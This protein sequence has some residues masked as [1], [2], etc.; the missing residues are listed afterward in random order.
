MGGIFGGSKPKPPPKPIPPKVIPQ[1]DEA[2]AKKAKKKDISRTMQRA[3]RA[4]TFLSE[5]QGLGG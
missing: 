2:A 3:G 1:P 5:G 4:S